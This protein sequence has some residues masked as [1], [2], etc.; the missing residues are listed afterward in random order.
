MLLSTAIRPPGFKAPAHPFLNAQAHDAT[1][2]HNLVRLLQQAKSPEEFIKL[3]E[4][5]GYEV[6]NA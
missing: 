1:H 3:L 6:S 2:E 4:R 5:D